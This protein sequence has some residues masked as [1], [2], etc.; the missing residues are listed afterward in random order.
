[1]AAIQAGSRR[2][3]G[4]ANIPV[5]PRPGKQECLP[6]VKMG[7][8]LSGLLILGVAGCAS[9]WDEVT[10]RNFEFQ[11]LY[12]SPDP[13][14]VLRD[15]NDGAKRGQALARL[16]EPLQNGGNPE[17]HELYVKVLTTAATSD[18]EPLCRLGAIRALGG[19]KD[20]RAAKALEEVYLQRLPFTPELNSVVRQ[21]ALASLEQTGHAEARHLLIRVARQPSGATESSFT[22]RQQTQDER[23]AAIRGL[24]KY[25]QYDSIETLVH[26]LESEKD[27]ALRSRAHESL[28]QATG[29]NLPA[30]GK[31]WRGLMQNPTQ[32]V[33]AEHNNPWIE[34]VMWWKK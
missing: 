19:Y 14:L 33:A 4:G 24:A 2:N 15:S 11:N 5:C 9:F 23:L 16:R 32:P 6:H 3:L 26:I 17:E 22:D 13:L 28:K 29:K 7:R 25:N 34:R 30:D 31:V 27:V 21:Q 18:R 8:M 1:M 10:S 12:A 20:P